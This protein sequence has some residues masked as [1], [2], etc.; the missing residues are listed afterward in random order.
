M[1][2]SDPDQKIRTFFAIDIPN[3]P[4]LD[5][6]EEYQAAIQCSLGPLKLV[7][8]HLMHI[9]LRFLGNISLEEA[10]K[11]YEFLQ[12]RVNPHFFPEGEIHKGSFRGVGHFGKRVFFVKID[13]V[14]AL[15]QQIN[16][17]I[18]TEL[19]KYPSI[20][21]ETKPYKPHLTIA[22]AR[23]NRSPTSSSTHSQN[24]GQPSYSELKTQYHD[25]FFGRWDIAQVVL[26]QSTLTP[27]GPIYSDLTFE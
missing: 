2:N 25:Y 20:K 19:E 11:L 12:V 3:Q 14:L 16:H 4:T 6:V 15:L 27:T 24:P 5:A 1:A 9:T 13:Q 18:E 17:T 7:Q 8:R 23:R 21:R 26:K 22:R 10:H